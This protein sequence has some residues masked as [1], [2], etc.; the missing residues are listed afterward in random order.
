MHR[1]VWWSAGGIQ[2]LNDNLNRFGKANVIQ[3]D[4]R[5]YH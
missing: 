4:L 1:E 2:L 5:R 3:K